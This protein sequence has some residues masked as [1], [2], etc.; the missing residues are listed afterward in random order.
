MLHEWLVRILSTLATAL[1]GELLAGFFSTL[2]SI[3]GSYNC[4][5]RGKGR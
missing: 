2:I 5:K 1:S 3:Q 4:R